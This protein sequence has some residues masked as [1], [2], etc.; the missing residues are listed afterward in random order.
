MVSDGVIRIPKFNEKREAFPVWFSQVN[1]LCAVKGVNEALKPGCEMNLADRY[2][3]V[4]DVMIPSKKAQAEAKKKN[5]LAMSFLT[6]AMDSNQLLKKVEA[7][8]TVKWP[9]GIAC[10]L[11]EKLTNKYKPK[12][13]VAIVEQQKKLMTLHLR[14]EQDPKE[15]CYKIV[16][17]NDLWKSFG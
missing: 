8:K 12:D 3:T 14:K 2:D 10:V 13:N 16:A 1:A 9:N 15:L 17:L 7:A 5:D 4:L 11:M 6:L